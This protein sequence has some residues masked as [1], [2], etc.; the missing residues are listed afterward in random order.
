MIIRNL[1][2][3]NRIR[4]A[5]DTGPSVL[6]LSGKSSVTIITKTFL[7]TRRIR[8]LRNPH[9]R[10]I[11]KRRYEYSIDIPKARFLRRT[12][13]GGQRFGPVGNLLY[14]GIIRSYDLCNGI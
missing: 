8:N 14:G 1:F 4:I 6:K 5:S 3:D 12:K 7:P 13:I 11:Y 10:I 9:I 2:I